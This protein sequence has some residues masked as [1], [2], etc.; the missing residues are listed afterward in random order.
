MAD[1]VGWAQG[2]VLDQAEHRRVVAGGHAVGAVDLQLLGDDEVHRERRG[3]VGPEQQ[4]GLDVPAT[5]TQ[6]A[7]RRDGQ[8]G[9]AERVDGDVRAATRDLPDRRSHV[10]NVRSVDDH[11]STQRRSP[12]QRSGIHVDG[13][14]LRTER[15]TDHHRRQPDPAAPVHGQPLTGPKPPVRR[16]SPERRREPAPQRRRRHEV[17]RLRQ[18]HEVRVGAVDRHE[19]GE[20]PRPREAGLRLVRTHLRLARPG[21]TSTDRTRTRTAPSPGRR[22]TQSRTPDPTEAT[23]PASS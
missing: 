7:H 18:P 13:D 10:L 16:Q 23:T 11:R 1:E 8:L 21:T 20:R 14:H 22:P 17:D 9:R 15:H 12:F 2:A 4:S 5:A 6:A 19:L 3:R